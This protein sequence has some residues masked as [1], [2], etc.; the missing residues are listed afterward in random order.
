[1]MVAFY[2]WRWWGNSCKPPRDSVKWGSQLH[3]F[4]FLSA[5]SSF[6]VIVRAFRTRSSDKES[7]H[8]GSASHGSCTEFYTVMAFSYVN[9]LTGLESATY[10]GI[11]W[12][13]SKKASVLQNDFAP[14][15][16]IEVDSPSFFLHESINKVVG[17]GFAWSFFYSMQINP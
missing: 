7:D 16:A 4:F 17:W 13:W 3:G 10:S 5:F 6:K 11:V 15:F 14:W 2:I 8:C 9:C 1:M 12:N